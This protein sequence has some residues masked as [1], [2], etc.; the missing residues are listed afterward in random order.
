MEAK[1]AMNHTIK[2]IWNI[3]TSV[4][5]G[6][7]VVLV[8]LLWG[9]RLVGLN[10]FFIQSSSMEPTYPTGS[11]V[12]VKEADPSKLEVGDV[13]TFNLGGDV[14]GTHRIIEVVPDEQNSDIVRFR[15][16]GDANE[17][18]DSGLVEASN[19][20]GQAVFCIPFLGFFAAYIQTASGRYLTMAV[21][22]IILLLLII[23]DLIFDDKKD[24]KEG[25]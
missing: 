1:T 7:A 24:K 23:P 3:G 15:T 18:A 20:V 2:R 16:K 6:L 5:V 25:K 21:A 10:P 8:I 4:L 17:E 13:I 12:Y 9:V 19:I 22:A 14:R 11:I